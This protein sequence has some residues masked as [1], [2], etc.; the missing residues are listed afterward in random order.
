MSKCK[1]CGEESIILGI[2]D[3]NKACE[4]EDSHTLPV[5]GI[6]ATYHQCKNCGFIFTTYFDDWTKQDFL[7]KIYNDDYIKVDPDYVKKRPNESIR[8]VTN[9]LK[10]SKSRSIL[11]YGAGNDA[12]SS[13]MRNHGFDA[14]GWDP[15]WEKEPEFGDKKFDVIVAIEVLEHTPKPLETTTEMVSF[16]KPDGCI[17]ISTLVNNVIGDHGITYWYIAPRNGHVCMHSNRSLEI[18]FEKHGLHVQHE[19]YSQHIVYKR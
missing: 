4:P 8:W 5:I 19:S 12:F 6:N 3:L 15:M 14:V 10:W 11:D 2:R 17:L 9:M 7:D 18:M 13:G 1:I 16:M